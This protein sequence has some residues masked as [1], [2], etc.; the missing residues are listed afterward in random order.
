MLASLNDLVNGAVH[1]PDTYREYCLPHRSRHRLQLPQ[2]LLAV[3]REA[4]TAAA[5]DAGSRKTPPA[6]GLTVK[7]D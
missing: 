4:G 2:R 5:G 1:N 3:G 6:G 7:P